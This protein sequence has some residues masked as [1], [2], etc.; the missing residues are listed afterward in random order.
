MVGRLISDRMPYRNHY[1]CSGEA[2]STAFYC[3]SLSIFHHFPETG[4][5]QQACGL[6]YAFSEEFKL[7]GRLEKCFLEIMRG[8]QDVFKGLT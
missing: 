4:R 1:T 7:V 3:N 2:T 5:N 6:W 8:L